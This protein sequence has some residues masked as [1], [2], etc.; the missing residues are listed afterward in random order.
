[1]MDF[2]ISFVAQAMDP[3][4]KIIIEDLKRFIM[5]Q[6]QLVAKLPI[7][8]ACLEA[9]ERESARYKIKKDRTNSF[10]AAYKRC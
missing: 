1:M 3:C 8:I 7:L 2:R 10:L 5:M 9:L 4:D 6:T